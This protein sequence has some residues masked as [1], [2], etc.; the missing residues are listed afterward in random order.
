MSDEPQP[1]DECLAIRKEW[2]ELWAAMDEPTRE[3][4]VAIRA[5]VGG[6][7]EDADRAQELVSKAK[8][9]APSQ[10]M[11]L[12]QKAYVHKMRTRHALPFKFFGLPPHLRK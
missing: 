11:V 8:I 5:L 9:P 2:L 4:S 10:A 1:C 6:T 7:E 12:I 3:A